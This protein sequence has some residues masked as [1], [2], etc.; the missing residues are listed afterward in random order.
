VIKHLEAKG[1]GKGVVNYKLR[2]WLI[3]RQ[4]YWGAP[5]PI[6]HCPDCGIVPVPEDQLPVR[7]PD[8]KNYQPSGT[9]ESPLATIPEF[10]NVPCPVCGKPARRETDTMGGFACSSWYFLRYVDPN[11]SEKAWDRKA[12]DYWLPVDIYVGGK[13]H[14]VMHLLYARFWT[15]ALYDAGL[16]GFTEPF[17]QLRNQGTVLAYTPGLRNRISMGEDVQIEG[18]RGDSR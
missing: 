3:S 15:K 12:L 14:A 6:I 10:V 17:T 2:D 9:G 1:L 18:Q 11:N 13:E 8:V 16:V 7:L 4:R 5:I